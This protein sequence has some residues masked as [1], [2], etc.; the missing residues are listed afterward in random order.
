MLILSMLIVKQLKQSLVKGFKNQT[1]KP[2]EK[3]RGFFV[4]ELPN[5][6]PCLMRLHYKCIVSF[7]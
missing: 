1:K 5:L 2:L 7:E 4:A 3:S 6:K